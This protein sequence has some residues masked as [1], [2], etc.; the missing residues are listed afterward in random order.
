MPTRPTSKRL[1]DPDRI[2]QAAGL[3]SRSVWTVNEVA[4]M[5]KFLA[6]GVDGIISDF[7][8]KFWKLRVRRSAN[9]EE[10][11]PLHSPATLGIADCT[12]Q[13]AI[14]SI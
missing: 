13:I 1:R 14:V 4:E 3:D 8:E 2:K 5:E 7:P 10:A 11:R 12:S 6:L 9:R